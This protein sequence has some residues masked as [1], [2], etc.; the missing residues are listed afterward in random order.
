MI[1]INKASKEDIPEIIKVHQ[2]CVLKTNAKVY[3]KEVISEWLNQISVENVT[4]QFANTDWYIIKSGEKVIGFAQISLSEKELYQINIL[5]KFQNR[6]FGKH[7]YYNFV[8]ELFKSHGI[9]QI[10]LNATLNAVKFYES[11]GFKKVKNISFKLDKE[12]VEMA[13]MIKNL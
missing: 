9:S 12:S 5:P 3:R 7:F 10:G 2:A 1:E 8:E 6:G 4:S 13:E 11:L